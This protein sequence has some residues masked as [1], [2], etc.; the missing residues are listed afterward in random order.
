MSIL[1]DFKHCIFISPDKEEINLI[2]EKT[3]NAYKRKVQSGT[4]NNVTYAQD[5]GKDTT[6]ITLDVIFFDYQPKGSEALEI[7]KKKMENY[8]ADIKSNY[9]N[10]YE[11]ASYFMNI[12]SKKASNE[13]PAYLYHPLYPDKLKVCTVSVKD[14]T[15]LIKDF[16]MSKVSVTFILVDRYSVPPSNSVNKSSIGGQFF[17][18]LR[19]MFDAFCKQG[20]EEYS[21]KQFMSDIYGN[22]I[23]GTIEN[24]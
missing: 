10:C 24:K 21:K 9:S 22:V 18:V 23:S 19:P 16:G 14:N 5:E 15:S 4:V 6:Q 11:Q 20:A 17:N 12:V 3:S 8:N 13:K 2:L 1:S 7:L